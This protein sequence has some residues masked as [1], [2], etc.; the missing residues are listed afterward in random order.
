MS[1]ILENVVGSAKM[2][3]SPKC[4]YIHTGDTL[5]NYTNIIIIM[6]TWIDGGRVDGWT[7]RQTTRPPRTYN[8]NIM[9][10]Q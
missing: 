1:R 2:T 3:H 5:A 8:A 7:E 4:I 10:T 6:G 9:W